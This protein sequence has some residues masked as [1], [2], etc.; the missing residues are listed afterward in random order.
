MV[1][2]EIHILPPSVLPVH[3]SVFSHLSIIPKLLNH[4][5]MIYLLG[6]I[7]ICYVS[8]FGFFFLLLGTAL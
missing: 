3:S 6:Q 4:I 2:E 8:M 7:F 1:Q 5:D